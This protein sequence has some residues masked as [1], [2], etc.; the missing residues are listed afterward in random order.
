MS[1]NAHYD[2]CFNYRMSDE[3]VFNPFAH[4]TS[5]NTLDPLADACTG[6][7]RGQYSGGRLPA[8]M[9][10]FAVWD[11]HVPITFRHREGQS[12][13]CASAA[14]LRMRKH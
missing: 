13:T 6:S 5:W 10:G 4:N 14:S 2:A 7:I 12:R 11:G 9:S 1:Y 8:D 3:F